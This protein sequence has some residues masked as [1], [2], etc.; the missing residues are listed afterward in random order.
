MT[1]IRYIILNGEARANRAQVARELCAVITRRLGSKSAA[2]DSFCAPLKHFVSTALGESFNK[3][4]LLRAYPELSGHAVKTMMLNFRS[5]LRFAYGND[6]LARLLLH[7]SLRWPTAMPCYYIVEDGEYAAEIMAIPNR[8]IVRV[9]DHPDLV[10]DIPY[11]HA[12][13]DYVVKRAAAGDNFSAQCAKIATTIMDK[14][15]LSAPWSA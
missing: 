5:D 6:V 13:P 9:I 1:Q 8:V 14:A 7:R 3:I 11:L 15:A 10:P 4:N 2:I 12:A